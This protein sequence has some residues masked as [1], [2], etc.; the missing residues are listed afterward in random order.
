MVLTAG[1]FFMIWYAVGVLFAWLIME[2]NPF[3]RACIRYYTLPTLVIF[4]LGLGILGPSLMPFGIHVLLLR[5]QVYLEKDK[6]YIRRRKI[7]R[8]LKTY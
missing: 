4:T 1:A 5:K 8:L 3:T 7:K 6:A 2:Y